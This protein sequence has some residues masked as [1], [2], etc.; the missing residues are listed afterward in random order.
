MAIGGDADIVIFDPHAQRTI[1]A[2][3]HHMNVDYNAFEGSQVSGEPVSVL[4]RGEF[5]IRDKEFVGTPGYG[6]YLHRK[7]F[8]HP[9]KRPAKEITIGGVS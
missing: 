2:E 5:V 9:E 7:R 6:Q 3:T 4:V 8:G 1:S